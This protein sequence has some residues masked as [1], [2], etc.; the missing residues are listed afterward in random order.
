LSKSYGALNAVDDISL[1]V[2]AGE[3]VSFLGPSGSGKTTT[4]LMIAG[5]ETPTRGDIRIGPNSIVEMAAHKRGIGMLFQSYALFP[6]MT[7]AENIA[8]PLRMRGV[9]LAERRRKVDSALALVKLNGFG[10]R[11]PS[12]LSGGQQQRVA[13]ARALVFEPPVLLLD[14]PLGALD[15]KLRTEM[16]LELKQ[17]HQKLGTTIVYVTH[18]QEEALTMSDRIA[19]FDKGRL[20][21]VGTPHQLYRE[22]SN[23]FVAEF[24][25]ETSIVAGRLVRAGD[26]CCTIDVGGLEISGH[27]REGFRR[28]T[29]QAV[30]T[31]RPEAVSLFEAANN[32]DN[33][34]IGT[35]EGR[36]FL[37]DAT[38]CVI[39][40]A[41]ALSITVKLSEQAGRHLVS[42]G[43]QIP[44]G[45]N[46]QDMLLV[47]VDP[48]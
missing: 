19:V 36:L 17:L 34:F 6:H 38:K 15:A 5:F 35:L 43:D 21:Q 2:G 45:W 42:V 26:G 30:F 20:S 25:G 18:D 39:R 7:V 33:R 28:P 41:E 24:I 32:R 37:G 1:Q 13:L 44:V 29:S 4:L 31:L 10:S 14:E 48:A 3:F 47:D 23:R 8:F 27:L 12:Q 22:P 11:R 9:P 16:Q 46:K 40:L